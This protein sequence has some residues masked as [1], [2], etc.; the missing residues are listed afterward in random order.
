MIPSRVIA[1]VLISFGLVL[2]TFTWT[3]KASSFSV[4]NWLLSLSPYIVSALLC[5]AFRK[6]HAAAGALILPA[7]LD[8]GA[9]YSA[10]VD[11]QGSTAALSLLVIPIWNILLFVPI[12][13]AIGWWVGRRI[14][15][16]TDMLSNKSLERTRE[17]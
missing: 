11:P 14:A 8:A 1:L 9:Y 3:V 4:R 6:P 13:A 7:I 10:F 17:R 12:G 16:T 15:M 2:H 5:F